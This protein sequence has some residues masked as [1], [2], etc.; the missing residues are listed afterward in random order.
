MWLLVVPKSMNKDDEHGDEGVLFLFVNVSLYINFLWLLVVPKSM[1][2]D[3]EHGDEGVLFLF[4]NVLLYIKF[5]WLLVVPNKGTFFKILLIL[6]IL[7]QTNI[8]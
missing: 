4:V 6:A 3:D 2:K 5:L 8:I 1:N 7:T